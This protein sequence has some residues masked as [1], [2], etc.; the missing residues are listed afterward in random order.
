MTFAVK[1]AGAV[2]IGIGILFLVGWFMMIF[3]PQGHDLTA[4]HKANAQALAQYGQYQTQETVLNRI[5]AEKPQDEARYAILNAA[6]PSDPQLAAAIDQINGAASSAGF[7]VK[8]VS[9]T[10]PTAQAATP[11]TPGAA[12]VPSVALSITGS[13]SYPQAIAFLT[14]LT[15]TA[16]TFVISSVQFSGGTASGAPLAVSIA[17]TMFYSH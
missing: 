6:V 4:A 15:T 1:R 11:A 2:T 16:R 5:L 17:C 7:S 14:N 8:N 13:G 10:A 12:G 3:R 9:P